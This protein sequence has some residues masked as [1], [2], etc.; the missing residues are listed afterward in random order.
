MVF[1]ADL[2]R[3]PTCPNLGPLPLLQ[4]VARKGED[5]HGSSFLS[6]PAEYSSPLLK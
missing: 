1:I 6:N 5:S 3:S 2:L 4:K